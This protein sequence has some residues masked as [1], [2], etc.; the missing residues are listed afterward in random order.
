MIIALIDKQP[1]LRSGLNIFLKTQYHDVTI[2][3]LESIQALS[4]DY[5]GSF[6]DLFIMG[7]GQ[8]TDADNLEFLNRAK[9]R[10]SVKTIVFDEHADFKRARHYLQ[11]GVNGYLCKENTPG[12]LS[13]CIKQVMKGQRYICKQIAGLFEKNSIVS[14]LT[15]NILTPREYE[16]ARLLV[17][18]AKTSWI[19]ERLERKASTIST[20][21][22]SIFKKYQ[23][24][25]IVELKQAIS[26][27]NN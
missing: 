8:K 25:N 26:M 22:N 24:E 9:K 7:F 10:H 13:N 18:G 4:R 15:G 14:S 11:M 20:I 12:E 1:I 2:V 6:P 27:I 16:I 21:K 23:V 3:E 19:A 5:S 17:D